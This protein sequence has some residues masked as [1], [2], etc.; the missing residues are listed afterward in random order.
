MSTVHYPELNSL[1]ATLPL[2]AG[3][4]ATCL[5][6]SPE[7]GLDVNMELLMGRPSRFYLAGLPV[8]LI[9][10]PDK[11]V[12]NAGCWAARH[13]AV[14]TDIGEQKKKKKKKWANIVCLFLTS[15]Q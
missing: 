1:V 15:L 13:I 5:V 12:F 3:P 7:T 14:L 6:V 10:E 8:K 11:T 2:L 9:L 4:A